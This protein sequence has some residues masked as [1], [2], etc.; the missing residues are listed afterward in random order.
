M[1]TGIK[2]RVKE[3]ISIKKIDMK[4]ITPY[5]FITPHM[6]LFIIFFLI[7]AV[8]G[9]Y[10]SLTKW[11][12]FGTPVFVGFDNFREILFNQDSTFYKQLRIG[13]GNTIKFVIICVPFSI[14]IPLLLASALHAKP[15]GHKIFQAIFSYPCMV[16]SFGM[17][18][19]LFI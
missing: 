16:V 13:L 5:L 15:K 17:D 9:L 3:P 1:N 2:E 14:I 19:F 18:Y 7:P 6:I 10:I 11:D 8:F 4:K 12:L